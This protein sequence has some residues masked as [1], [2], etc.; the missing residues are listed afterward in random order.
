MCCGPLIQCLTSWRGEIADY[1]DEQLSVRA[2]LSPALCSEE[3]QFGADGRGILAQYPDFDFQAWLYRRET[4]TPGKFDVVL[5]Y[6]PRVASN[7]RRGDRATLLVKDEAGSIMIDS[8]SQVPFTISRESGAPAD[9]E[10]R[11]ATLNLDGS[12][13]DPEG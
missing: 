3:V 2:C 8:V 13:I 7:L 4:E 6:L 12:P 11:A 10:C 9:E 1:E 5:T